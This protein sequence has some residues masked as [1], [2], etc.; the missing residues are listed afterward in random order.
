MLIRKIIPHLEQ[1]EVEHIVE[2]QTKK[3]AH[4]NCFG[5]SLVNVDCVLK[6]DVKKTQHIELAWFTS[7]GCYGHFSPAGL[8]L[9]Q[10]ANT[11]RAVKNLEQELHRSQIVQEASKVNTHIEIT[12]PLIDVDHVIEDI[13]HITDIFDTIPTKS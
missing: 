11:L 10:I 12:M 1:K 7:F 9:D 4:H 13:Y 3:T 2:Y 5:N 6:N 8:V